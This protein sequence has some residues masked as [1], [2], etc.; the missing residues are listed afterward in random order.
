MFINKRSHKLNLFETMVKTNEIPIK[1]VF[2]KPGVDK[3]GEVN[4]AFFEE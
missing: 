3:Q 4:I 2:V 1:K